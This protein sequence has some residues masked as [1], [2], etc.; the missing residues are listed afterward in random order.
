MTSAMLTPNPIKAKAYPLHQDVGQYYS[1]PAAIREQIDI[2]QDIDSVKERFD[3][4]F[5]P[6][7]DLKRYYR[8]HKFQMNDPIG[9]YFVVDMLCQQQRGT[10]IR[11]QYLSTAL[12]PQQPLYYWD[13]RALG[14]AL[15]GLWSACLEEYRQ[16]NGAALDPKWLPLARG[17]DARGVYYCLDPKGGNEGVLWLLRCRKVLMRH[18]KTVMNAEAS[19][20][21]DFTLGNKAEIG[22]NQNLAQPSDLYSEWFEGTRVREVDFYLAQCDEEPFFRSPARRVQ[23]DSDPLA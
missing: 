6:R 2:A 16:P 12:T 20:N 10:Y 9:L 15:S 14:R 22:Y 18:A 13:N 23:H 7:P 21:F 5:F 3:G 17:R 19:G 4:A 1:D 8:R 11:P